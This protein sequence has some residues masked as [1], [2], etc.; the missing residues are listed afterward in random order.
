MIVAPGINRWERIPPDG[1]MPTPEELYALYPIQAHSR[2]SELFPRAQ[3]V[4]L[5]VPRTETTSRVFFDEDMKKWRRRDQL[6]PRIS[7]ERMEEFAEAVGGTE[8]LD[9]AARGGAA[10]THH[11]RTSEAE[12][13]VPE[14][15]LPP[16]GAEGGGAEGLL[17]FPKRTD[18]ETFG[19]IG[20]VAGKDYYR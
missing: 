19:Y 12:E 6:G 9:D 1:R 10:R 11:A 5:S 16:G 17:P 7:R 13:S 4:V 8:H 15:R 18:V 20:G 3:L 2:R 14:R